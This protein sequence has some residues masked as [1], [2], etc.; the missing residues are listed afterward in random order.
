MPNPFAVPGMNW[1]MPRAPAGL[2]AFG[3]KFDS[4]WSCAAR[5]SAGTPYFADRLPDDREVLA[6]GLAC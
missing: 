2:R 5:R 6:G 4:D 3:L 1:A